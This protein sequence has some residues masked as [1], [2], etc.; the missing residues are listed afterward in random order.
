MKNLARAIATAGIAAAIGV[1]TVPSAAAAAQSAAPAKSSPQKKAAKP[2]ATMKKA[3]T[4][5]AKS[6]GAV[7]IY[8]YNVYGNG[9][10]TSEQGP[11]NLANAEVDAN[12]PVDMPTQN[13]PIRTGD[14]TNNTDGDNNE[15]TFEVEGSEQDE[16]EL[17]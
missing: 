7:T 11:G 16:G 14:L 13:E 6:S 15:S 2:A 3:A 12:G 1:I 8:V 10:V 4:K 17:S 5:A 9:N